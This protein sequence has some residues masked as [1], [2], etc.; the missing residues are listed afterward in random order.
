MGSLRLME[1]LKV[2]KV[3]LL[4]TF[5]IIFFPFFIINFFYCI[6]SFYTHFN[7]GEILADIWD[8]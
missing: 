8:L 5:V 2:L 6:I 3:F 7:D 4:L 1:T